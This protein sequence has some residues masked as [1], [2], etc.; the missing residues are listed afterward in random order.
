MNIL[1]FAC[2]AENGHQEGMNLRDY[3]AA[4]AMQGSLANTEVVMQDQDMAK[5][6]YEMADAMLQ[7]RE[8]K[9]P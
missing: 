4:R 9:Q 1:A 2:A 7:A 6:S 8:Q 5:W 3:F